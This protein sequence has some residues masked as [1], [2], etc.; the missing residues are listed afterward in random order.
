MSRLPGPALRWVRFLFYAGLVGA[1]LGANAGGIRQ[2]F[3][4]LASPLYWAPAPPCLACA[5]A[6]FA[7]A[8]SYA[9][10]LAGATVAAWRMPR[11][12]HLAPI[13]LVASTLV[14]KPLEGVPLD[15]GRLPPER[16]M[17]AMGFVRARAQASGKPSC[18][19]DPRELERALATSGV[20]PSGYRR[21][22]AGRGYRI[23]V[24]EGAGPV[25]APR[26]GDE[27]GTIYL[28][29]EASTRRT[30]IS[31]VV[32]DALPAGAPTMVSDGVGRPAVL[33]SEV[34]P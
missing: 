21:F 9:V 30:W 27:P 13:G 31:G 14:G 6:I 16:M 23:Q 3:R 33:V 7:V 12:V 8:S 1:G 20:P 4:I 25:K 17:E 28:A 19:L 11:W 24:T 34:P 2:S 5:V 15:S 32:S 26:P 10:W 22:G 29:C 18:A